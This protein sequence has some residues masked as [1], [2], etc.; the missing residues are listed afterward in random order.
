MSQLP[1]DPHTGETAW[2]VALAECLG[3]AYGL[4]ACGV[5]FLGGERDLNFRVATATGELRL[6]KIKL[7]AGNGGVA[8]WQE[9]IL[10]HLAGRALEFKVPTI[11]KTRDGAVRLPISAGSVTGSLTVFDWVHGTELRK[12]KIHDG[13]LLRQWGAVAAEITK[14]LEGFPASLLDET[15]HWDLTR[16]REA[17]QSCA[18]TDPG[19]A[20]ESC[21]HEVLAWIGDF[22]PVLASLPRAVVHHDLNDSNVLVGSADDA[23]SVVGVLDFNDA[24][25][26]VRIAELAVA[27]AYAM[28]RKADPLAALGHVVAGY[29]R[30]LALTDDEL[31]VVYPLAVA[32]LCVQALT[33]TT[34]ERASPTVYG[35]M[36]VEHTMPAL[37]QALAIERGVAEAHIR[38]VCGRGAALMGPHRP[39][40]REGR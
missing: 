33:W 12:V 17:I 38:R 15:H 30:V 39:T 20:E 6:A 16:A 29:D 21:A 2:P 31:R 32:R 1:E 8:R 28:L 3:R 24:L 34:R 25:Y 10:L 5:T 11:V 9:E 4:H 22:E 37:R 27:G 40:I 36:R 26:S 23:G 18:E 7:S 13:S 19:L 14:A 35:S